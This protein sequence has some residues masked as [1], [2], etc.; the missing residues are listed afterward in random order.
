VFECTAIGQQSNICHHIVNSCSNRFTH[1]WLT[2]LEI[3]ALTMQPFPVV[4]KS[5]TLPPPG[6]KRET[7]VFFPPVQAGHCDLRSLSL[8]FKTATP[9]LTAAGFDTG[10]ATE[11]SEW[12]P[13]T[14]ASAAATSCVC[15]QPRT[16]G[17]PALFNSYLRKEKIMAWYDDMMWLMIHDS[18]V[19][20]LSSKA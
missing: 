4:W 16:K 10:S 11:S 20:F 2:S 3:N 8:R 9:A 1:S 13:W 19:N 6:P 17:K 15:R 18:D 14:A 7:K 12:R 5:D